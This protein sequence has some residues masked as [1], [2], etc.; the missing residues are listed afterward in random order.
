MPTVQIP[1]KENPRKALGMP[2][3]STLRVTVCA[4]TYRRPEGLRTLLQGLG[5]QEFAETHRPDLNVIIVDNEGSA[6]AREICQE[7]E[8]RSSVPVDY[9]HEPRRGIPQARNTCLDHIAPTC[10]FFAF[11]DDDEIPDADWLEQLLLAQARTGADVVRGS[12]EPIFPG[13]TPSWI[14]DGDFFGWPRRHPDTG[15]PERQDGEQLGSAATNNVLVRWSSV[16]DSGLRFDERLAFTGGTDALFFQQM[17]LAGLRIVYAAEARVRETI[18]AERASLRYLF[19]ASYKLGAN[20]LPRKLRKKSGN[21]HFFRMVLLVA[22]RIPRECAMIG[23]GMM[24]IL[25]ALLSGTWKMDRLADGILR[26]AE[27]LGG[28]S[29]LFGVKYHH[30][31]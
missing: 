25:R 31:R 28:L 9:V 23:S 24:K 10:D 6:T 3:E 18:P 20:K 12:V 27:G 7:F 19:R 5:A 30:Y 16:R 14:R 4:C 15:A 8:Q 11:I 21:E 29:G 22:R 26:I 1:A 2:S 17:S 13:D